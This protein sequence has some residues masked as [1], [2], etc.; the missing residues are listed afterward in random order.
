[1]SLGLP[2][3]PVFQVPAARGSDAWQ[4]GRQYILLSASELSID[5]LDELTT[6]ERAEA[7]AWLDAA[8]AHEHNQESERQ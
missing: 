6:S 8:R 4:E 3:E 7:L 2:D 1:M 5:D